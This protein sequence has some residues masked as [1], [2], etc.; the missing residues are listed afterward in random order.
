MFRRWRRRPRITLGGSDPRTGTQAGPRRQERPEKMNVLEHRGPATPAR[1]RPPAP[2]TSDASARTSLSHPLRID[3][4]AAGDGRIGICLCPGKR[5]SSLT[6]PRWERELASD[7]EVI[8]RWQPAA[9]LSLL[10]EREFAE[11]GVPQLGAALRA[12]GVAWHTLPITDLRAP[13]ARFEAG[14][15]VSGPALLTQLRAG[16]R[17]LIHCRGGLGR[18]GTVAA[19]L[20]MELDVPAGDAVVRVRKARP[21]A[22]ETRAQLEYVLGLGRT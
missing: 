17:I 20:L 11:L 1:P 4:L 9:V 13:D 5:C 10:E 15:Q 16:N 2:G 18:S 7:L 14:W 22:I 6:G 19:R 8:G 3:E 21:G 12:S